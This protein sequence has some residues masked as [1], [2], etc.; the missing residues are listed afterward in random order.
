MSRQDLLKQCEAFISGFEG[1]EAQRDAPVDGMLEALRA[2]IRQEENTQHREL[3]AQM[4]EALELAILYVRGRDG[5]FRPV[6]AAVA[7]AREVLG[8]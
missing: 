4:L 7:A 2:E 5:A 1:D 8:R 6:Q 3:I